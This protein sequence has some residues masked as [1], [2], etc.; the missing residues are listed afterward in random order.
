MFD[1]YMN[2]YHSI[3]EPS[4]APAVRQGMSQS[5]KAKKRKEWI[6][7]AFSSGL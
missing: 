2:E 3:M 6:R 4:N 5:L 1:R 7:F